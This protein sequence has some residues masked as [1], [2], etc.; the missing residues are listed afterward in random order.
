MNDS[1]EIMILREEVVQRYGVPLSAVRV[2]LAPY[3]ICPLGAHI[4]P[5]QAGNFPVIAI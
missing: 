2:V 4:D 3:R 1:P 5:H